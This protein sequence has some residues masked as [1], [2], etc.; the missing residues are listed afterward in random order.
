MKIFDII[1]RNMASASRTL[2]PG[3]LPPRPEPFRGLIEQDASLCTGCQTCSYVCSP[4]AITFD[5]GKEAVLTWEYFA[6]QCTFCGLCVMYCPTGA[7]GNRGTLPQ[8]GGDKDALKTAHDIPYE[9]CTRCG[10]SIIPVPPSVAGR[11]FGDTPEKAEE[12]RHLC[13]DCRR[14]AASQKIRDAFLGKEA[15]Q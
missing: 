11:F 13:E 6:G 14:H 10:I 4:K 3:D 15:Q 9:S 7:L 1:R 12:L 8:V 5:E 2:A